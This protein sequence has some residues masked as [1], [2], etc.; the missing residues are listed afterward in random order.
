MYSRKHT[1]V[2]KIMHERVT[3]KSLILFY[4]SKRVYTSAR[5]SR[6]TRLVF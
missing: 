2:K 3:K 5:G 1:I 6:K 4:F